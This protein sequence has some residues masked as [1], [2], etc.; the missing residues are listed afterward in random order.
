MTEGIKPDQIATIYN[1]VDLERFLPRP[2]LPRMPRSVLVFSNYAQCIHEAIREECRSFGIERLDV[3]GLGSGRPTARPEEILPQYDIVFAKGRAAIE[4]IA[5]GCAVV[6]A[7]YSRAA[8]IVT[9][10]NLDELRRLNFGVRTLQRPLSREVVRQALAS[11]DP[12]DS[13]R[14]AAALRATASLSSAV[15]QYLTVYDEVMRAWRNR[16]GH[17]APKGALAQASRYLRWLSPVIKDRHD[18][19]HRVERLSSELASAL[20][21][22]AALREQL[23]LREEELT[24]MKASPPGRGRSRAAEFP[25]GRCAF[26]SRGVA[27]AVGASRRRT[28]EHEGFAGLARGRGLRSNQAQDLEAVSAGR[29]KRP[30]RPSQ[31]RRNARPRIR[32]VA[33]EPSGGPARLPGIA[34][35]GR[36][37]TTPGRPLLAVEVAGWLVLSRSGC[38]YDVMVACQLPKLIARVRFP[39]PAPVLKANRRTDRRARTPGTFSSRITPH[40]H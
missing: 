8:G 16:P 6:V 32:A 13:G 26:G 18:A 38:G 9:S 34:A 14:V 25:V 11:Y 21:E 17:S 37:L 20:S 4:A 22:A 19:R 3:I 15:D 10:A 33:D 5:T 39:L 29:T 31:G 35:A 27:R 24:S 2:P 1:F 36:E 30:W 7:D 28:D 40:L 23:A 12:V